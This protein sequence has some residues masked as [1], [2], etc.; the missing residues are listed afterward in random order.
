[1]IAFQN[2]LN[3]VTAKNRFQTCNCR[4]RFLLKK[5]WLAPQSTEL[6]N[7]SCKRKSVYQDRNML[8]LQRHFET[9]SQVERQLFRSRKRTANGKKVDHNLTII[10]LISPHAPALDSRTSIG[11]SIYQWPATCKNISVIY[12]AK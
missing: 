11:N 5:N 8:L 6:A 1:M 12:G 4:Y 9:C 7:L 3:N 2:L 10:C